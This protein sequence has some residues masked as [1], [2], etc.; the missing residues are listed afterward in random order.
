MICLEIKQ[1]LYLLD[2]ECIS[3]RPVQAGLGRFLRLGV[4][5]ILGTAELTDEVL[6]GRGHGVIH[7]AVGL[8]T[9]QV[10]PL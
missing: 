7:L 8:V 5:A 6:R 3:S 10:I 1:C 2:I 4:T 9:G